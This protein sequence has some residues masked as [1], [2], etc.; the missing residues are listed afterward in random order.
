MQGRLQHA[1]ID[2]LPG[3]LSVG[4]AAHSAQPVTQCGGPG[5]VLEARQGAQCLVLVKTADMVQAKAAVVVHEHQGGKVPG[6]RQSP[7]TARCREVP[8]DTLGT[9]SADP[10]FSAHP[11]T[12]PSRGRA[13]WVSCALQDL[14][15]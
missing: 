11:E 12:G 14:G 13:K 5:D 3:S 4:I 10:L 15:A 6:R 9:A 1:L 2:P 8:V 7:V